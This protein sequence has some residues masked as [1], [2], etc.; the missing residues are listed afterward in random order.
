M[1]LV[2]LAISQAKVEDSITRKEKKN[3]CHGYL[4]YAY[5]WHPV[6]FHIVII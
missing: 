1:A 2:F 5:L 4:L 6:S 3:I